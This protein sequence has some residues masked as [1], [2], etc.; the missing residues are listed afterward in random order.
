VNLNSV[1]LAQHDA[2]TA[3]IMESNPR[4]HTN[5][6]KCIPWMHCK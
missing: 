3:K 2:S 4:E 1:P 6:Q 5:W